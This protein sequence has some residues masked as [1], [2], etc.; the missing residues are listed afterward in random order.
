LPV[1]TL[2]ATAGA[3]FADARFMLRT[4]S[5][6]HV[7]AFDKSTQ[8]VEMPGAR[9]ALEVVLSAGDRAARAQWI[10]F[11]AELDGMA[12]R[13]Y[14]GDPLG[15]AARGSASSAPGTPLVAG[16]SQ[17]GKVLNIDG[18]PASAAGYLLVGDYFALD[19]PGGGR[20]MHMI[21]ADVNTDGVGLAALNFRPALRLPPADNAAV[22]VA[23]ATCVMRLTDDVQSGWQE[24]L[25]GF[26]TLSFSAVE[27]FV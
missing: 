15:G 3:S 18:A 12:G 25:G 11:L 1:L 24:S 9:W 22:I 5:H 10:A 23:V 27:A 20:S 7:S 14:A 13:F 21:T 17:T 16:A 2:P 26:Y 4:N 19:L 6:A 8:T